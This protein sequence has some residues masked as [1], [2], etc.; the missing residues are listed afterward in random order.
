M[1]KVYD[2][3]SKIEVC[4][5]V[6][7]GVCVASFGRELGISENTLY[8]WGIL[9]VYELGRLSSTLGRNTCNLCQ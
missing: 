3:A 2:G 1:G 8:T 6:K 9:S 4:Q 5:R 7:N